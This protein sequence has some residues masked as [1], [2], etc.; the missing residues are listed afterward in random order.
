MPDERLNGREE[1]NQ[2]DGCFLFIRTSNHP[3]SSPEVHQA[4]T[5]QAIAIVIIAEHSSIK[6][7]LSRLRKRKEVV[8]TRSNLI[9]LAPS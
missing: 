6:S 5:N 2:Q 7:Q 3:Q 8:V 1:V 9:E 4:I